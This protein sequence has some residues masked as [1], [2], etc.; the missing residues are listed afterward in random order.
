MVRAAGA[1]IAYT[2]AYAPCIESCAY[3]TLQ[4]CLRH[5]DSSDAPMTAEET[6]D[7]DEAVTYIDGNLAAVCVCV[8]AGRRADSVAAAS[9]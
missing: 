6:A 7:V 5:Q 4:H 8:R 9:Y 1:K 2:F 3:A